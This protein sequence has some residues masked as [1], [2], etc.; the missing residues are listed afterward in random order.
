MEYRKQGNFLFLRLEKGEE[1]TES[2]LHLCRE[3]QILAGEVSGI[4]ATNDVTV[5]LFDTNEKAYHSTTYTGDMEITSLSGNISRMDGEPYLHLHI[6]V[7]DGS[8]RVIG[9]HLNRCVVSVTS[10]ITISVSE[11]HTLRTPDENGIN[12]VHFSDGSCNVNEGESEMP[13]KTVSESKTQQIQLI[14][15]EHLNP[16]GRLFGGQLLSW[17]DIVAAVTARR[18]SETNVTTVAIDNLRFKEGAFSGDTLLLEGKV[19]YVGKTSMEIRVDTY[20]EDLSGQRRLINYAYLVMVA[21]DRN[22]KPTP[23]PGLSLNTHMEK[24]EWEAGEK[25]MKLRKERRILG[26]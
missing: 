19:T 5:G 4:G 17:I 11:M 8:N 23:V 1:I 26:Y 21:I 13:K 9:G 16:A 18:H 3:E 20:R 10:E 2:L 25:R 7:A 6:T 15:P 14:L 22:Q 24:M 12:L